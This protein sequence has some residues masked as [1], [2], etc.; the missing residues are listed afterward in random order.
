MSDQRPA[1]GSSAS[2]TE[3]RRTHRVRVRHRLAGHLVTLDRPV[4][5][6]DI[7]MGGFSVES[8]EALP[9]GIH[10]IRLHEGDRWS[11]TVTAAS[12]HHQSTRVA[13]GAVRYVI[14]FEYEDQTPDTQQTLRVLFEILAAEQGV[15]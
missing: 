7:S 15:D 8:A 14:G 3:L 2:R 11:L 6:L 5:V 1:P 4:D 12:R 9:A 10:V 13:D